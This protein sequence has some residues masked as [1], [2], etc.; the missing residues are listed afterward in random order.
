MNTTRCIGRFGA[1]GLALGIVTAV[2]PTPGVA[3]AEP[4]PN[5]SATPRHPVR[6]LSHVVTTVLSWVGLGPSPTAPARTPALWG[7]LAWVRREIG[8]TFFNQTPVCAYRTAENVETVEVDGRITSITGDLRA[9]DPDG[10]E[11]TFTVVE[12]PE[13]GTVVVNNDGTFTYT[14]TDELARI[15]GSDRFVVKYTD[16]GLHLH[17]LADL[18]RPGIHHSDTAVIDI[19]VGQPLSPV[20]IA[21]IDVGDR[22]LD[23]DF[24][25][26]GSRAYVT[27]ADSNTVSVI[28]T[29]TTAVIATIPVG[30]DPWKLAVHPSGTRVYVTNYD[31][32]TVNVIDT[33]THTVTATIP[34]GSGAGKGADELAF[35]PDGTKLY[36]GSSNML[37]VIDTAT[38]TVVETRLL[39][40]GP[41][42][43]AVSPDGDW[44]YVASWTGDYVRKTR[45][46]PNGASV[47]IGVGNSPT[48]VTVSP[49]G[50]RLYVANADSNTVSVVNT[51][52]NAVIK[53]IA[54]GSTP[55]EVAISPVGTLAYVVNQF[56]GSVSVIDTSTNTVI[57]T[58]KVNVVASSIAVS[59]DGTRA[60]VTDR[61]GGTIRVM[62]L[63]PLLD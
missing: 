43:I 30:N 39:F 33:A 26:D 34:V 4:D 55:L 42:G 5:S 31:D 59:P 49:D 60:Y 56:G 23:V 37:Q 51:A 10:D 38:N 24:T 20:V 63:A 45:T 48:G 29:A 32:Y 54:V 41:Y 9:A 27:N 50:T 16:R 12:P 57:K 21:T 8:R 13:H 15:G 25:P 6:L 36:V 44:V 35:S 14:P 7:V 3:V 11:L 17:S 28:D 1:L 58:L 2:S 53:T 46:L 47:E 61:D 62:N 52:T 18:L 22:S 40:F 19:P